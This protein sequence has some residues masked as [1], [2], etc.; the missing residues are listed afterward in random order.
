MTRTGRCDAAY[1]EDPTGCEGPRDAVWVCTRQVYPP[2]DPAE[3]GGTSG[4][5]HHGSRLLALLYDGCVYPGPSAD[6]GRAPRSGGAAVD[7]YLRA[8]LLRVDPRAFHQAFTWMGREHLSAPPP[9]AS[10]DERGERP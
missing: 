1:T 5:V 9:R 10:G 4:C 8:Q 6:A 7:A 2:D 3:H